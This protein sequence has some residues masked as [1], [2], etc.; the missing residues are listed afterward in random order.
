VR[1]LRNV[2]CGLLEWT[3]WVLDWVPWSLGPLNR[4]RCP[5]G[6]AE[7][8]FQ[9]EEKWNL[10]HGYRWYLYGVTRHDNARE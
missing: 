6:L 4:L 3:C 7:K 10:V 8:A 9:L 1:F 2:Y 5:H